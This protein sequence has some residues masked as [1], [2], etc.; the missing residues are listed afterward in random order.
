MDNN[1]QMLQRIRLIVSE[2]SNG[3]PEATKKLNSVIEKN[4]LLALVY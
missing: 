2:M 1:N 4:L 3:N